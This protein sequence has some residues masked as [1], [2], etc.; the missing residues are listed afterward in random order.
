MVRPGVTQKRKAAILLC[1]TSEVVVI[2]SPGALCR[3]AI[4]LRGRRGWTQAQLADAVGR[5]QQWVSRF[6]A[7]RCEVSAGDAIAALSALGAGIIVRKAAEPRARGG[8]DA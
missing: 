4:Y 3:C 6:E 2:A 8:P 7:G 5:S 1:V